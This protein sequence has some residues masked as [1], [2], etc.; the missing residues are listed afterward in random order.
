MRLFKAAL[1]AAL[2]IL[3]YIFP[4]AAS[5]SAD[6]PRYAYVGEGVTAYLCS[7]KNSKTA[8]FAIP[9]TYC[10]E[11]LRDDGI[12]YFCRYA[13]DE[14]D[15]RSVTGYCA[16]KDLTTVYEPLENEY[17]NMTVTVKFYA[18]Q[19]S[20]QLP[21]MEIELSAAYYGK[22]SVN[23]APLAYVYCQGKFGYVADSVFNDYPR[24]DI[25]QQTIAP[26]EPGEGGN[27]ALITAVVI[28]AIAVCAVAALFFI[29]KRPKLPPKS[30][31]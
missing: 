11:I 25:P 30:E 26:A 12:W 29:S 20:S 14:G 13:K 8:L 1:C 31:N 15:Y 16:K 4:S 2:T 5:A 27:A 19:S 7:E 18:D 24:N 10:V 6:S 22:G 23:D 21:P 28:T 17:L 3:I 9:E